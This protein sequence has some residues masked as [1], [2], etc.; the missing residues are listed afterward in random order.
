MDCCDPSFVFLRGY[1]KPVPGS[2]FALFAN[3]VPGSGLPRSVEVLRALPEFPA[4]DG[5]PAFVRIVVFLVVI[6]DV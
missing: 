4:V 1:P 2:E 6:R 5:G 3:S